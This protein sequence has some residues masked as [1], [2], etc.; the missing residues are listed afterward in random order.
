VIDD[1]GRAR[2][3][4]GRSR[5]NSQSQH[6]RHILA[7][8]AIPLRGQRADQTGCW[9]RIEDDLLATRKTHIRQWLADCILGGTVGFIVSAVIAVNVVIFSGMSRGYETSIPQVFEQ[10]RVIGVVASALLIIGP[11]A[12]VFLARRNRRRS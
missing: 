3:P 8:G 12:G 2:G 9:P 4:S 1:V 6:Y 10:N 11:F 7:P 5:P